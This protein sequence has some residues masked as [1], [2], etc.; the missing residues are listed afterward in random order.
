M[1]S[2]FVFFHAL[3]IDGVCKKKKERKKC[4]NTCMKSQNYEIFGIYIKGGLCCEM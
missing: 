3:S 1:A 4:A 2:D